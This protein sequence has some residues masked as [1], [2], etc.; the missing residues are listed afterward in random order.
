M[1]SMATTRFAELVEVCLFFFIP[2]LSL[3]LPSKILFHTLF[4]ILRFNEQDPT[5]IRAFNEQKERYVSMFTEQLNMYTEQKS[6][7]AT[8][9]A[10]LLVWRV[11][12][13]RGR[14]EGKGERGR[15]RDVH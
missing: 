8:A 12:G 5:Y 4:S 1:A 7:V 15:G 11:R 6:V 3:S 13:G 14:E 9:R 10:K 2:P